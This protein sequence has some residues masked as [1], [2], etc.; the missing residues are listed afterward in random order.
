[1]EVEEEGGREREE[2]ESGEFSIFSSS[3]IFNPCIFFHV[4]FPLYS[5]LCLFLFLFLIM[6]KYK[7]YKLV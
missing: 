4:S 3:F 5:L 1:M 7:I 6:E 2:R